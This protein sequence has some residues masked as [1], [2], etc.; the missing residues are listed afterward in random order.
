MARP[1]PGPGPGTHG[2]VVYSEDPKNLVL[3]RIK[4]RSPK[5]E[6]QMVDRLFCQTSS[7]TKK[8]TEEEIRSMTDAAE[9]RVGP[10]RPS[11]KVLSGTERDELLGRLYL[12]ECERR[13]QRREALLRKYQPEGPPIVCSSSSLANCVERLYSTDVASRKQRQE[14]LLNKFYSPGEDA[15]V[16]DSEGVEQSVQRVYY[17]PL[18]K[19]K[20]RR[21]ALEQRYAYHPKPSRRLTPQECQ[22]VG[23]RLVQAKRSK[24]G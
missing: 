21:D 16:L 4:L 6:K 5:V 22:A 10:G 17:E 20:Q 12:R 19:A 24:P 7:I 2:T 13:E 8:M 1:G 11:A 14:T 18:E 9:R 15:P 3:P 23:E